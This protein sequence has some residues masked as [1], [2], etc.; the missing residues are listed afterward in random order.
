MPE[1]ERMQFIRNIEALKKNSSDSNEFEYEVITDAPVLGE[2]DYGPYYFTI[3]EFVLHPDKKVGYKRK[4]CLRIK[5]SKK[6]V[7]RYADEVGQ[8][9]EKEGEFYHGGGIADELVV[10]AS[11]FLRRRLRLGRIVRMDDKPRLIPE[12]GLWIDDSIIS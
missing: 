3:W 2:C 10:L 4:L 11:L 6:Q 1:E 8:P 12:S 9:K 5:Q 7:F